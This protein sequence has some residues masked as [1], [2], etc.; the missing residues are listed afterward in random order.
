MPVFF[1]PTREF[2][3]DIVEENNTLQAEVK[4]EEFTPFI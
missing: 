4:K 1:C 2:V 3:K